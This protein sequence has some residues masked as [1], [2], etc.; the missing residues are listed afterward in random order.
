MSWTK[1]QFIVSAFEEIGIASYNY[2]LSPEMMT[3]A[4]KRLD[5]MMASWNAKGMRLGYPI[6]SNP[7]NGDLDDDTYVPDSANEAVYMN[8]A[9]KLAPMVGK[10]VSMELKQS[11][12]SSYNVALAKN[13]SI[14]EVQVNQTIPAGAGNKWRRFYSPYLLRPEDV[15]S[16]N[17]GPIGTFS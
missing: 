6:P 13:M 2:D 7:D 1:R 11:A 15:P 10:Q 5:A 4:M 12:F 17:D 9:I 8:L 16:D 3:T 14:P